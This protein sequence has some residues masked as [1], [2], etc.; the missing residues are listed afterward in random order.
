M[1]RRRLRSGAVSW[2]VLAGWVGV[3]LLGATFAAELVG[4]RE[5]ATLEFLD[6]PVG[7]AVFL[8][9]MA[10]VLIVGLLVS[11]AGRS[12]WDYALARMWNRRPRWSRAAGSHRRG[13]DVKRRLGLGTLDRLALIETPPLT[14]KEVPWV[15]AMVEQLP[16]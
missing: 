12:V 14:L 8:V 2:L 7:D 10:V 9:V 1:L 15:V 4:V 3:S 13:L 16:R 6:S 5:E 11:A